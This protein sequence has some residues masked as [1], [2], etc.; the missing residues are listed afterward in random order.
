MPRPFEY[1]FEWDPGKARHNIRRHHGITFERGSTVFR[2]PNALSLYDSAHSDQEERWITLG[3]DQAGV[4]LVICHTYLGIGKMSAKIRIFS[5]RK[6]T[7][8]ETNQYEDR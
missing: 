8:H 3:L 5:A 2:D 4:L 7:R 1:Q 6:A